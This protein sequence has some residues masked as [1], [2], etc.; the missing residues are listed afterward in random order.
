MFP[1]AHVI[2]ILLEHS[3]AHS[4]YGRYR[5]A[6]KKSEI[7]NADCLSLAERIEHPIGHVKVQLPVPFLFLFLEIT[8]FLQSSTVNSRSNESMSIEKSYVAEY[9]RKIL[10][11]LPRAN[12]PP[13]LLCRSRSSNLSPED[14]SSGSS[15]QNHP[16]EACLAKPRRS[17]SAAISLPSRPLNLPRPE[18]TQMPRS[19]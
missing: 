5:P 13:R 18:R 15:F 3:E 2:S 8:G 11:K 6:T 10:S 14:R 12:L 1:I 9:S 17:L 19:P 4:T 7:Q 16:F